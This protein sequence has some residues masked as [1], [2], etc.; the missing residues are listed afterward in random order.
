MHKHARSHYRKLGLM[1]ALSFLSMYVLMY[2]M[3]DRMANVHS[4][5][6]QLYMAGLMTA[7]MVLIEL[8][9]M[10]AMYVHKKANIVIIGLSLLVL[11]GCWLAIRGQ[12]G[13]HDTQFLRS[14]IPHHAGAILMCRKADLSD[15]ELRQLCDHIIASQQEEIDRMHADLEKRE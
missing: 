2:A 15:P 14:M 11:A 5:L 13:I 7:P 9:L 3:V 1:V 6:N 12:A 10:W 8:A 4:N